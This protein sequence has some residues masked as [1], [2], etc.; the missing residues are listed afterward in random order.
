ML[1]PIKYHVDLTLKITELKG[2]QANGVCSESF[3]DNTEMYTPGFDVVCQNLVSILVF[4]SKE[5]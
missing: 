2:C 1:F 5:E 4:I 3:F